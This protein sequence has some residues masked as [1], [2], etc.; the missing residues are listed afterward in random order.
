MAIEAPISQ[1]ADFFTGED[2]SLIF[3]VYQADG[4][5]VQNITGWA[6]S[7]M[8]K[9]RRTDADADALITKTTSSG[10]ALTTPLSGIC[11]VTVTDADVANIRG[12]ELY[13]HELKRTT[14]GAETVLS[15]GKFGLRQAVHR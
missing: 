12:G 11:T 8:V 10:I 13:Y 7:W 5:T 14:D 3:T 15:Y 9:K 1:S 4:T 6:L 2:K